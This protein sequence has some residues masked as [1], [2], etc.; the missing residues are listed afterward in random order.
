[1]ATDTRTFGHKRGIARKNG[2]ACKTHCS[3]V[4]SS[5]PMI[6]ILILSWMIMKEIL[7]RCT[8]VNNYMRVCSTICFFMT[9]YARIHIHTS[10]RSINIDLYVY[11]IMNMYICL[12][13]L[14]FQMVWIELFWIEVLWTRWCSVQMLRLQ[15]FWIEVLWMQMCWHKRCPLQVFEF[16]CAGSICFESKCFETRS[17]QSKCSEFICSSWHCFASKYYEIKHAQYRCSE[18][19]CSGSNWFELTC[20]T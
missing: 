13:L 14:W 18:E 1:M 12:S 6:R 10:M 17:A 7:C 3:V 5:R 11:E 8:C 4:A 19:E 9:I 20:L 2:F 15:M 16:K